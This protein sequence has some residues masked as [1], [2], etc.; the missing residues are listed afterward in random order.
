MA[1]K[2]REKKVDFED[3]VEALAEFL[4]LDE[5]EKAE[6]EEGYTDGAL[7]Y[8]REEYLV[9]TDDEADDMFREQEEQLFDELGIESFS[10][11][12][13]NWILNNAVEEDWF[14]DAMNESNRYY[15][16]DIA[17]EKSRNFENRLVEECY[18][19][20]LINDDDFE[21]DE[22]GDPDFEQCL[23]DQDDLIDRMVEDM[24]EDDPIEWYR[25]N[26][27]DEDLSDVVKEHNLIDLNEVIDEVQK[28]DGRGMLASWD[29]EEN[30]EG[31][32][33]IYRTN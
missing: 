28:W 23:V 31:E 12:F 13:Q 16:E 25:S 6:I 14:E 26:F 7:E 4:G 10:K 22:D 2:L 27:G 30:S 20:D 29:G 21:K 32:F 8:G 24:A 19:R 3:R 15:C 11:D 1:K 17:D 33:F 5:E 9:L 18:D